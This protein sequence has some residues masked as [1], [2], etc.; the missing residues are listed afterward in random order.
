MNPFIPA[1]PAAADVTLASGDV[2]TVEEQILLIAKAYSIPEG[3][4]GTQ[5]ERDRFT[6]QTEKF[7]DNGSALEF[8]YMHNEETQNRLQDSNVWY[9]DPDDIVRA[10]MPGIFGPGDTGVNAG[11][12]DDGVLDTAGLTIRWIGDPDGNL[13]TDDGYWMRPSSN[14]SRYIMASPVEIEENYASVRWVSPGDERLRYLVG[15]SFYDYDYLE[16]SYGCNQGLP[17]CPYHSGVAY[18]ALLSGVIPEWSELTGI[19]FVSDGGILSETAT[20]TA[21]FFNVN[22][23]LTDKVT[24]SAEGRFQSDKIGGLNVDTGLTAEV[25]TKSFLP[26][27]AISYAAD[28]DRTYYL[29][30]SK[31]VNPA[32]INVDMLNS[33]YIDSIDAGVANAL[34]PYT[35]AADIDVV[36][37][38]D[39]TPG[40][41]GLVDDFDVGLFEYASYTGET[42]DEADTGFDSET[43]QSYREEELTNIEFGF[44]GNLFDGGLTYAG[45]IFMIDWK[46]QLQNGNIEWASPCADDNLAGSSHLDPLGPSPCVVDGESY[47]WVAENENTGINGLGLNYGDVKIKGIEMEGTYRLS[48][49]WQIRGSAS[50]MEA[51]YDSF[52]DIAL[53][54]SQL[55]G[56]QEDVLGNP[57]SYEDALDIELLIPGGGSTITSPCFVADGKEVAGQPKLTG[58]LSPSYNTDIGGMR[59]GARLDLRYEGEKWLQSGN[60][61]KYPSV[62]TTNVSFSLSGDAWAATLYVTNLTDENSPRSLNSS[63]DAGWLLDQTTPL[64]DVLGNSVNARSA[65]LS[66]APRVPRTIGLRAS[67]SF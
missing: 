55:S 44:K 36:N 39:L 12:V 4:R 65:N 62:T 1:G 41:D 45:A 34:I 32:G 29:Q 24:L 35:V 37:N 58:S 23:D 50:Y 16:T 61:G 63:S 10:P 66:F 46:D 53:E 54:N 56:E 59:F 64:T 6:L 7:F 67:Y 14:G 19:P 31:G 11:L 60:W 48:R 18:G 38:A 13:A 8:S 22:Y 47:F 43:F 9:Y 30:W 5:S 25:T 17:T 26:R 2:L 33:I 21:A 42:W 51:E 28:E 20:N 15:A 40:A 52:C 3:D 27:F 57:F 49:N